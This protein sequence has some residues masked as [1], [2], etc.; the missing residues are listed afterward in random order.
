[1]AAA[2]VPDAHGSPAKRR[3]YTGFTCPACVYDIPAERRVDGDN[4]CLRCGTLFQLRRFSPLR[5]AGALPM[6]AAGD[7]TPC[8]FHAAN[9]AAASCTRCGSFICS[10]CV[11]T[12]DRQELCPGCFDRLAKEGALPSARQIVRNW[13][14]MAFHFSFLALCLSPLGLLLGPATIWLAIKGLGH[15]RRSGERISQVAGW[16]A[17]VL[18]VIVTV[19]GGIFL[20]MMLKVLG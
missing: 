14:G 20:L 7:S 11:I 2:V 15:N 8:A 13:N 18:G 9:S 1:M 12:T 10:L 16:F 6:P 19:I 5:E 17:L 4:R 3:I